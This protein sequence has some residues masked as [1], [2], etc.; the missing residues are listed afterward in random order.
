MVKKVQKSVGFVHCCVTP[1]YLECQSQRLNFA[2]NTFQT[3]STQFG[4]VPFWWWVGDP[5]KRDRIAWQLDKLREQGIRNAIVSYNHNAD[6]TPN[7]GEPKVF[8]PEWW[9]LFG[10]V[11]AEC[12]AREMKI[13]FQDYTLLGPV[14]K[15]IGRSTDQ[16]QGGSM[17]EAHLLVSGPAAGRL[18]FPANPWKAFV[19][20]NRGTREIPGP[21]C[22]GA[23]NWEVAEGDW[24][25]VA[26][27]VEP[28]EFDPMHPL[29]GTKVIEG[30]YAPF[31]HHCRGELGR[32]VTVSFQDE[33]DFGSQMPFWSSRLLE[34]FQKH[35]GYDLTLFLP[36]LWHDIGP[37]SSKVRID[38]QDVVTT[39]F[40]KN[41]FI[42]I[43]EWHEQ[44][45]ILFGHDNYGRGAIRRGQK[46]YGDPFRTQRWYSAPGTDDPKLDGPRA[47][48]GLKVSSSIA[49][50]YGRQR[51]WCECFHSSGWGT[52]PAEVLKGLHADFI[53]GAT[54]VNLHGL[55]YSTHGSW[56]EWAPPDFHFRQPYWEHTKTFNVYLS[57]L[58][59]TLSEGTHVCDV[60]ILYPITSIEAGLDQRVPARTD[61]PYSEIQAG[62]CEEWEDQSEAHAFGLGLHLVKA[63]IDFDFID[64]QSLERAEIHDCALHVSGE[65]YRVLILPAVTAVR[66]ST[67]EKAR[68]FSRSGGVVIA[69]GCKPCI[70]ERQGSN[71]PVLDALVAGLFDNPTGG[72]RFIQGTYEAVETAL[73]SLI[74][75]DFDPGQS[76]LMAVHRRTSEREIYF[77]FNPRNEEVAASVGFRAGGQAR[78]WNAWT[79]E[80]SPVAQEG[81]RIALTLRP[82]EAT[83]VV[84]ESDQSCENACEPILSYPDSDQRVEPL[85][86][87]G[88]WEFELFPTMDNR[89]GDFRFPAHPGTIGPEARRFRYSEDVPE[90]WELP[91]FDDSLWQKVTTSF[92][93]RFWKLGPVPPDLD[94]E[95]LERA[96]SGSGQ[97]DPTRPIMIGGNAFWW[98]PYEYSLRWG[99][100]NDAHLKNWA[101]GPHGLKGKVPDEFIDLHSEIPG[102]LWFLWTAVETEQTKVLPLVAGSRARYRIWLNGQAVLA[103]EEELPPGRQSIWDLPHYDAPP[104]RSLVEVQKGTNRL[105]VKLTQAAGQRSRAYVAFD[106][107]QTEALAL[108]WFTNPEH[109]RF[110]YCP[111]TKTHAGHYRFEAPP[112]LAAI[113]VISRGV[114]SAWAEGRSLSASE[115]RERPDGLLETRFEIERPAFRGALLALRVQAPS[116]S[117][118]GDPL[119]EPVRFE[120][121][122]GEAPLGD[123]R[124]LG[125]ECY[126][127]AA[128]Y[129]R[130]LNLAPKEAMSAAT[131]DLGSVAAT[132][133]VRINGQTAGTLVA[134]PWRLDVRGLLRPG[135]NYIEIQVSN[136]LANH[137]SIGIPTPYFY[138]DQ[139]ASGLLGPV[140]LRFGS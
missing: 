36:A 94:T 12:K 11:M 69:Y 37:S 80:S 58:C 24:L 8:S 34:E 65:A 89:F 123:W 9:D 49:H 3:P 96:L 62:D 51:V 78:L 48:K 90:N 139:C 18:Q 108:R 39:L 75:R 52:T 100:E 88:P 131:L 5:L 95:E 105:L 120:C 45:G 43:F 79:G 124:A 1:F 38:Y 4:P 41:Y 53:F 134:P 76:G 106:L 102:A 59:Q 32:T 116:G 119:P 42:P 17:A 137:Y 70:S 114:T 85:L 91:G 84:F 136:T 33:L 27:G 73:G 55:Y 26:I 13:G 6:G 56:W 98:T 44:R 22:D 135:E 7:C 122:S 25:V 112:G 19:C 128:W 97:P 2:P 15:E 87:D 133:M 72:S 127:G 140:C 63:G 35:K 132:A 110:N 29:S 20:G 16:M 40:E 99:I 30:F 118:A 83:L 126:S 93:P 117:F 104:Q 57:R 46:A 68:E 86:I 14:L 28:N 31:E 103:Q 66:F 113:T 77:V 50:L 21:F 67:L 130:A 111:G 23:L 121:V 47:F 81:S 101:S 82:G 54:V 92:G 60:A 61:G 125:L 64:F 138:E 71:D 74:Q 10:W 109:P 115:T 129:R 107:P